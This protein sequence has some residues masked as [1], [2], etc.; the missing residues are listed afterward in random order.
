MSLALSPDLPETA[1]WGISAHFLGIAGG[2]RKGS[3]DIDGVTGGF[4][5]VALGVFDSVTTGVLDGVPLGVFN[6][7]A[8]GFV[9]MT[10]GLDGA[11]GEVE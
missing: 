1:F 2:P 11:S 5:G 3:E 6:G 4:V 8:P 7:I 9:N 10:G